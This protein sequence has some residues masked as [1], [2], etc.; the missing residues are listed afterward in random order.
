MKIFKMGFAGPPPFLVRLGLTK[1]RGGNIHSLLLKL[2]DNK[3][4]SSIRG[5]G[6][7]NDIENQLFMNS[8]KKDVY[9]GRYSMKL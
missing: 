5:I 8:Y 3:D 1:A 4:E 6:R 2:Y 9:F 7:S